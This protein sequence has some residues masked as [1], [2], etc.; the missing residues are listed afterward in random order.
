MPA[1]PDFS[2]LVMDV[3]SGRN[4]GRVIWQPRLEFWYAVNKKR[5]AIPGHLTNLTL[6]GLYDYCHA[7]IR[8]FSNPLKVRYENVQI[9]EKWIDEKNLRRVWET[10]IGKLDEILHYDEW[11]LSCYNSEYMLKTPEDFKIYEFIL[12]DEHWY[13][14]QEELDRDLA[15]VG[16]RGV[17]MFYARRSPLQSLFIE[18]MGFERTV[19]L[20]IDDPATIE[21]HVDA[22]TAADD[23]MYDVICAARPPLFNFGENI[24]AHMDPPVYW[25]RYLLPYYQKRTLQLHSC[26]IKTSIHI[27]GAMKPLLSDIPNCP[28]TAIEACTPLPQGDV[29]LDEIKK[30]LADTI[31]L[32]GIP[33]LYFL[34]MY[35]M[36]TL[37]DCTRQIVDMFYPNLI[38]GISDEPPP[39]SDIER[40]RIIGEY[41][42]SLSM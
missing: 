7:S 4:P 15:R 21:R 37:L 11:N 41:L 18:R 35:S 29:S 25:R 26:G 10:P 5:G 22:Q 36:D 14:D 27:D 3:Y 32:D 19:Y 31:L 42:K 33:A 23:A 13:W 28:T 17:S 30:A 16:N 2:Q 34:P 12:S 1:S 24:D 38:L 39:D 20:M 9:T 8:Y 6:E 40:V